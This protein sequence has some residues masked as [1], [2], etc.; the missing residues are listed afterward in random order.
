MP[1]DTAVR[2]ELAAL[3]LLADASP[4]ELD[5]LLHEMTPGEARPGQ[6]LGRQGEEGRTF[7]LVLSG[8]MSV[9]VEGRSGPVT[10]AEPGAG[11]IVGELAVLR[12]RPRTATVTAL[13]GCRFLTG[14]LTAMARLV[15]IDPVRARLRLLASRRLAE[16]IRP[17]TVEIRDGSTLLLRPLL[18]SDR[19][20]FH[21][22]V[23]AMSPESRRRRFFALRDPSPPLVDYLVD[24]DYVD[25]FAW[26]ALDA[27]GH[28]GLAT[29]RYIRAAGSGEAEV[30]FTTVDGQQGRGIGT[31]MLGALGVAAVEAGI[32]AL[33]AY[34]LDENMA[35]RKVFAK[36]GGTSRFEEP[37][38]ILV[39]VEA[40]RA[41]VLLEPA[42][43]DALR[44]AVTDV[45]TAASIALA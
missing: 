29:A 44:A 25:H 22:A 1:P 24:I 43:R 31:M 5:A 3:T 41:A 18:P 32:S 19:S 12:D 20:A 9:S 38:V 40:E 17:V 13:T 4:A 2:D 27:T 8:R 35:M 34:V 15:D 37:G 33:V 16:D 10:L 21:S 42:A 39:T 11:S 28:H 14:G 30:A 45:V 26:V 7:W 6:V 23:R 36:A